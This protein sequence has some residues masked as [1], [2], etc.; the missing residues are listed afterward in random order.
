MEA[1]MHFYAILAT[2]DCPVADLLSEQ[3]LRLDT[4]SDCVFPEGSS[5][6]A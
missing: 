1:Q 5:I 3:L 2:D 6:K 4:S